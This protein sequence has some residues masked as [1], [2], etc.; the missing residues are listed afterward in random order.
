MEDIIEKLCASCV[1]EKGKCK[2]IYYE[3]RGTCTIYK[4]IN[5]LVDI[6]K[7]QPYEKFPYNVRSNNEKMKNKKLKKRG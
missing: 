7:I 4:C 6:N 2:K 1:N 3:K 5:Y